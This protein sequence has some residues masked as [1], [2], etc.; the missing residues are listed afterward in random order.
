MIRPAFSIV[1]ALTLAACS[2]AA[3]PADSS[4][5][6]S[7]DEP[8]PPPP[9]TIDGPSFTPPAVPGAAGPVARRFVPV[10]DHG[11]ARLLVLDHAEDMDRAA[12]GFGKNGEIVTAAMGDEDNGRLIVVATRAASK[13]ETFHAQ[14]DRTE[15]AETAVRL[16]RTGVAVTAIATYSSKAHLFGVK[17]SRPLEPHVERV[18]IDQRVHIAGRFAGQGFVVSAIAREYGGWT[19]VGY[20]DEEPRRRF[21]TLTEPAQLAPEVA[22]KL[23]RNEYTVS[24]T[25]ADGD[26]LLSLVAYNGTKGLGSRADVVDGESLIQRTEELGKKGWAI[27]SLAHTPEGYVLVSTR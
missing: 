3:H 6:S 20:K 27:T 23:A 16:A 18:T 2:D 5:S 22:E 14:C 26:G 21:I 13:L 4:S 7:N 25:M 15:I 10:A 9:A 17:T 19:A 11:R 1:L 12:R 24:G 8:A